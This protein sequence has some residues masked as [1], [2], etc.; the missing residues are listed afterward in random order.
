MFC[1]YFSQT[2]ASAALRAVSWY[3]HAATLQDQATHVSE[4]SRQNYTYFEFLHR[5]TKSNNRHSFEFGVLPVTT[6]NSFAQ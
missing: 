6:I 2:R 5:E 3:H 4:S 1:K